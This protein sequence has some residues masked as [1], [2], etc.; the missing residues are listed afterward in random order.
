VLRLNRGLNPAISQAIA[1]TV[2]RGASVRPSALAIALKCL[3]VIF[4]SLSFV[5]VSILPLGSDS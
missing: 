2:S 3:R 1:S 5:V 4:F